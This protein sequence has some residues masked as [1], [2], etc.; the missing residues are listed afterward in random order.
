[1]IEIVKII[2][3]LPLFCGDLL[4]YL[5]RKN[6]VP[7]SQTKPFYIGTKEAP[8]DLINALI[9][10]NIVPSWDIEG[11]QLVN[12]RRYPNEGQYSTI[13]VR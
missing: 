1:M 2:L 13:S 7:K 6:L 4:F 10:V 3:L 12:G 9:S 8:R 11:R 5:S